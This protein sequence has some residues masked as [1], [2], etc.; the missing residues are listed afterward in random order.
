MSQRDKTTASLWRA[1]ERLG[2][3]AQILGVGL[4]AL[5]V[6]Y[7][8][9]LK[10]AAVF[11]WPTGWVTL[12]G[13]GLLV[14]V[15]ICMVL[16]RR[17]QTQRAVYIG[18]LPTVEQALAHTDADGM[19]ALARPLR[20]VRDSGG[21]SRDFTKPWDVELEQ[22]LERAL[23]TTRSVGPFAATSRE[24]LRTELEAALAH[25][26]A[27]LRD[28]GRPTDTTLRGISRASP[29]DAAQQLANAAR[30]ADARINAMLSCPHPLVAAPEGGR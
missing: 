3:V 30:D 18:L 13:V 1:L 25:L 14:A 15:A 21:L 29:T 19:A 7:R 23:R 22:R 24:A 17:L 8:H 27:R 9:A 4:C 26:A 28:F 5:V 16:R 12:L 2:V 6:L 10:R 20:A 11:L